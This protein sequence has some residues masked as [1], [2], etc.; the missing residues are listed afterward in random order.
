MKGC[1]DIYIMIARILIFDIEQPCRSS[2]WAATNSGGGSTA[3]QE[4]REWGADCSTCPA[5]ATTKT[6]V[7]PPAS[8]DE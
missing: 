5:S 7:W 3:A 1:S 6:F 4:G 8:D 2:D